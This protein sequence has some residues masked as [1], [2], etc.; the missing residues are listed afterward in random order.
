M[1]ARYCDE[2]FYLENII[3]SDILLIYQKKNDIG[4]KYNP[5]PKYI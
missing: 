1:L 4:L 2:I 5:S 3:N